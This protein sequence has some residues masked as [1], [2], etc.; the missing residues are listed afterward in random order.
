MNSAQKAVA[1]QQLLD[2]ELFNEALEGIE[3]ETIQ[4]IRNAKMDGSPESHAEA[5]EL[6]RRLQTADNFRNAL[7]RR[8]TNQKLL[9]STE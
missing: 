7:K 3:S 8:V 1:A 5:L 4:G 9:N 2:N 6:V